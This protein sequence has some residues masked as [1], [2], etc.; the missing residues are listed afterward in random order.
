MNS[1]LAFS[2]FNRSASLRDI[3]AAPSFAHPVAAAITKPASINPIA[4]FDM[5]SSIAT[6]KHPPVI[7]RYR[8]DGT[9]DLRGSK[10][11]AQERTKKRNRRFRRFE[12]LLNS[13]PHL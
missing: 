12:C 13:L 1:A 7:P 8:P 2:L 3:P 10:A 4:L 5:D 9:Q 11:L 6:K